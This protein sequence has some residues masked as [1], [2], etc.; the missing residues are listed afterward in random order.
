MFADTIE[1]VSSE[2]LTK[3]IP[4]AKLSVSILGL[5]NASKMKNLSTTFATGTKKILEMDLATGVLDQ[6]KALAKVPAKAQAILG[7][8]SVIE[9]TRQNVSRSSVSCQLASTITTTECAAFATKELTFPKRMKLASRS[10]MNAPKMPTVTMAGS[11]R[12]SSSRG[13]T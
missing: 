5:V 12:R 8:I 7:S 13:S 1:T 10:R 3:T 9:K 11:A 4:P 2:T 6:E